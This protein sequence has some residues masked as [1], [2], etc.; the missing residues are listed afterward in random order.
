MVEV[1]IAADRVRADLLPLV[2]AAVG[3]VAISLVLGLVVTFWLSGRVARPLQALQA[4]L[5]RIGGGDLTAHV[6]GRGERRVQ[7]RLA[8]AIDPMVDGLRER[9]MVKSAFARYVSQQVMESIIS[10]GA[11]AGTAGPSPEDRR[12]LLRHPRLH[13]DER[14]DASRE[15]SS[16][17]STS[18]SSSW[19]RSLFKYEGTLDKFVGDGIMALFGAPADPD[20][21]RTRSRA[22]LEMQRALRSSTARAAEGQPAIQIG[23]G[24]NTGPA[25]T[26]AI[27]SRR[28]LAVHGDRRR[29][30]HRLA[31][32]G[33]TRRSRPGHPDQRDV[34][35][36]SNDG[37]KTGARSAASRGQGQ[38]EPV[39][40]YAVW[41][42]TR[43]GRRSAAGAVASQPIV[44]ERD[45]LVERL[46]LQPLL[47]RDPPHQA[48]DALDVLGAAEE[49]ARGGRRL[50]EPLGGL[51]VL[52]ER[53]QVLVVGAERRAELA[54]PSRRRRA[55]VARSPCT[56][57]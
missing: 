43:A 41:Y 19:S 20:R 5:E 23:I 57:S 16:T 24:I 38:A 25:V 13:R 28:A 35:A 44:D 18:T 9:E 4:T 45:D 10:A 3:S 40:T 32:G 14:E 7:R 6:A 27:G 8:G 46:G 31:P 55:T 51:R 26:G 48:V 12:V 15:T 2:W 29:R 47:L 39:V 56:A 30:E 22:A 1:D 33:A 37:I 52:L 42:S 49:R 11:V 36:G 53:H 17:C 54:R 21:R 34:R 50:A